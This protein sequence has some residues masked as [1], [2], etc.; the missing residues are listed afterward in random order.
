MVCPEGF[1]PPASWF[2]AKRSIQ[3][4]YGHIQSLVN[5]SENRRKLTIKKT[6]ENRLFFGVISLVAR[7]ERIIH[8]TGVRH[9]IRRRLNF[10]YGLLVTVKINSHSLLMADD[11][12]LLAGT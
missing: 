4:S 6:D 12:R 11:F 8:R 5:Y 2:E 3:M 7:A 1:E 10:L 9:K